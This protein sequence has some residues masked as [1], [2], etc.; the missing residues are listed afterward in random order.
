MEAGKHLD[1]TRAGMERA[2]LAGKRI[3]RPPKAQ[4]SPGPTSSD[5]P[6]QLQD[7]NPVTEPRQE[8]ESTPE[9]QTVVLRTPV[10]PTSDRPA[11]DQGTTADGRPPM[12]GYHVV[13]YPIGLN[14]V[15]ARQAV[16]DRLLKV[17]TRLEARRDEAQAALAEYPHDRALQDEFYKATRRYHSLA[18][19][20]FSRRSSPCCSAGTVR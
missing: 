6:R 1:A 14:K 11:S 7:A 10:Q 19:A 16:A 12:T 2:R 4:P 20:L 8:A 3:G 9:P 17:A 18:E 13:E 15:A 5:A